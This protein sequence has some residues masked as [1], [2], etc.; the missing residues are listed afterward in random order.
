[1][2]NS[3]FRMVWIACVVLLLLGC[4]LLTPKQGQDQ[5][6]LTDACVNASQG[7]TDLHAVDL[8][9][10][11]REE[12]PVLDGS[13]FDPALY[14]SKLPHLSMQPGEALDFVYQFNPMGSFPR[15]YVRP[16]DQARYLTAEELPATPE[17]PDWRTYVQTDGSAEGFIE[18]AV[19]YTQGGQFYLDWHANYH[20]TQA[21][22]SSENVK[23]ILRELDESEY[24]SI[25]ALTKARAGLLRPAPAVEMQ[26]DQVIV[27]LY[28]FTKWGGFYES[29]FTFQREFPHTLL[30]VQREER[31]K[32]DCGIMF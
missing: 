16:V 27:T 28:T 30:D 8:P 15:L 26:A 20:D 2:K 23:D 29:T 4:N 12:N 21:V 14:F 25:D 13:E 1:M 19:L 22:C 6:A 3:L 7:L 17:Q 31:V 24:L 18:L 5:Q 9:D 11:L 32:Y 10:H